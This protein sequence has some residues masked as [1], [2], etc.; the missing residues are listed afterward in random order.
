MNNDINYFQNIKSSNNSNNNNNIDNNF[1]SFFNN[2]EI[3]DSNALT[4]RN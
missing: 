3:I 2:K 4:K 1:N